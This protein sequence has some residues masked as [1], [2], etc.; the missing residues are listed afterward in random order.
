MPVTLINKMKWLRILGF[1]V[2]LGVSK[3]QLARWCAIQLVFHTVMSYKCPVFLK[4]PW[5]TLPVRL[6][7]SLTGYLSP[8]ETRDK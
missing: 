7:H 4:A 8:L 1:F 2:Y 3:Q 5:D 6:T